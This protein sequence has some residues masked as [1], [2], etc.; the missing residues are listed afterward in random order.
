MWDDHEVGIRPLDIKRLV[1]PELGVLELHCQRL[2]DPQQSHALLV[3]TAVQGSETHEK[4]RLLSGIG[5]P[6]TPI[7][8][9]RSDAAT[10]S[11]S[12]W[13]PTSRPTAASTYS[14]SSHS[15]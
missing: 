4:L 7:G 11:L 5:S 3:F 8:P 13:N 10:H 14:G 15:S 2:L 9:V 12:E 1:H 6:T